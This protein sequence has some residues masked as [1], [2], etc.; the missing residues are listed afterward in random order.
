MCTA[1]KAGGGLKRFTVP[2]SRLEHSPNTTYD[3]QHC[4]CRRFGVG[5]RAELMALLPEQ[6]R[7]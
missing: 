4:L 5:S 1:A 7:Q 2:A 6:T 3:Y